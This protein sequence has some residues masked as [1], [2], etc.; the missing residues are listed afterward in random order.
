[1][2]YWNDKL[3][4]EALKLKGDGFTYKEISQKLSGDNGINITPYAIESR[5]RRYRKSQLNLSNDSK[6]G[7]G[8]FETYEESIIDK[9]NF[10][11]DWETTFNSIWC[12]INTIIT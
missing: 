6:G 8:D 9:I 7:K 4:N 12:D 10:D 11:R 2:F 3:T 1:M 5:L